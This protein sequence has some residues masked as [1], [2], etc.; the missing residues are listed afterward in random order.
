MIRTPSCTLKQV[1]NRTF[2]RRYLKIQ[3]TPR[4][5]NIR[6]M[7]LHNSGPLPDEVKQRQC[8]VT[9]HR[10]VS[11]GDPMTGGTTFSTE[12]GD[13]A[14][15]VGDRVGIIVNLIRTVDTGHVEAVVEFFQSY[16]DTFD[17]PLPSSAIGVMN[18]S[19]RSRKAE[20]HDVSSCSK[21]WLITVGGTCTS[22]QLL[23]HF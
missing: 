6:C 12:E 5:T 18:V 1:I 19:S 13:N 8:D 16:T 3:S 23:Q 4:N 2:E 7:H 11:T 9:Q 22:I 14:V 17:H 21:T 10:A 15:V 20:I